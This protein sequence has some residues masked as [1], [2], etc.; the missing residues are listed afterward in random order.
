M[1]ELNAEINGYHVR[2]TGPAN[3]VVAELE[4]L[5]KQLTSEPAKEEAS[6]DTPA[7]EEAS[8]EPVKDETVTESSDAIDLASLRKAIQVANRDKKQ[9]AKQYLIDTLGKADLTALPEDKYPEL[10]EVVA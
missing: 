10:M 1:I 5:R 4:E 8:S 7:K 3:E 9:A 6:N 2:I